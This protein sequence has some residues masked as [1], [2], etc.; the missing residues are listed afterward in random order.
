LANL[1]RKYAAGPDTIKEEAQKTPK[2]GSL[3]K[4]MNA[5]NLK[6]KYKK[7][8]S[9]TISKESILKPPK[10]EILVK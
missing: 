6:I 2:Y 10:S 3:L 1:E 5:S 9:A 4:K 8:E 7:H